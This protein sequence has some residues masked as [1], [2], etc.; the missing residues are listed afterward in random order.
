[1]LAAMSPA[2]DA[3]DLSSL[4][5]TAE[6]LL[7]R[8]TAHTDNYARSDRSDVYGCLHDAERTL[9]ASVRSI[10]QAIKLLS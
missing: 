7:A 3:A 1:M 8:V 10:E 5:R 6:T 9:R 4:A 2:S